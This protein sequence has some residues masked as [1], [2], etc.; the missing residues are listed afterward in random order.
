MEAL[1][2]AQDT[3]AVELL[4]AQEALAECA[5]NLADAQHELAD[6]M[7]DGTARTLHLVLAEYAQ[8]LRNHKSAS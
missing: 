8:A 2:L 1:T 7:A 5:S 4:E 3:A 6:A